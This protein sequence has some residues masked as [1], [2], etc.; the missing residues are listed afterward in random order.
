MVS[1]IL[2][3]TFFRNGA[4]MGQIIFFISL[5]LKMDG[6]ATYSM[7]EVNTHKKWINERDIYRKV[8]NIATLPANTVT[9]IDSTMNAS[10]IQSI[11]NY[12]CDTSASCHFSLNCLICTIF[13]LHSSGTFP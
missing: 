8:Y 13:P 4:K 10:K 12:H 6:N 9:C 11:L 5:N 7:N 2:L 3:F 1:A